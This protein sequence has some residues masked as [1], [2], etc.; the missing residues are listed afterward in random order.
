MEKETRFIH[1]TSSL[2]LFLSKQQTH[3]Q[4]VQCYLSVVHRDVHNGRRTKGNGETK[5]SGISLPGISILKESKKSRYLKA[6]L[7]EHNNRFFRA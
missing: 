6:Y 7:T 2:L 4:R 1:S 3:K 5:K